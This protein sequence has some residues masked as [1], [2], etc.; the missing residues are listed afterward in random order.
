MQRTIKVS[1][2]IIKEA[3]GERFNLATI[4][5]RNNRDVYQYFLELEG[6][7][8][9]DTDPANTK[10][11]I[12]DQLF[13]VCE[14]AEAKCNPTN[15]PSAWIAG[16]GWTKIVEKWEVWGGILYKLGHAK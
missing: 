1:D 2:K 9:V 8:V 4:S 13:V 14:F 5:E 3:K 11:T 15:N 7:A 6:T 12:T 16:F 10:M